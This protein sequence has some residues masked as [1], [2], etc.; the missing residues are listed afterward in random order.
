MIIDLSR[1]R[2]ANTIAQALKDYGE[3]LD[4]PTY[5]HFAYLV[6]NG[7][8]VR[9]AYE[10]LHPDAKDSTAA[11]QASVL[12]AHPQMADMIR[13]QMVGARDLAHS[14]AP[15]AVRDLHD[16]SKE[17]TKE[18]KPRI[19]AVNSLL[20]RG[21]L[22]RSKEIS[23]H[24]GIAAMEASHAFDGYADRDV[25]DAEVVEDEPVIKPTEL[26][27]LEPCDSPEGIDEGEAMRQQWDEL[28]PIDELRSLDSSLFTE[29]PNEE[30]E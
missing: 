15:Q 24:V 26:P 18:T 19:D 3:S 1:K 20:D 2:S 27:R 17:A 25:I 9:A 7:M 4:D 16:L 12:L 28:V 11:S 23:I 29:T 13:D 22:P 6:A 8:T 14:L 30:D 5:H 21:G 10:V